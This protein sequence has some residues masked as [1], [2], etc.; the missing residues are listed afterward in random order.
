MRMIKGVEHTQT[1]LYELDGYDHGGMM[2]PAL[3]LLLKEV[4]RITKE[5]NSQK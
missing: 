2:Q 4:Q 1:V 5:K 3:P